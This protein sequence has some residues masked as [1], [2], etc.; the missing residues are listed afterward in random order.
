MLLTNAFVFVFSFASLAA[1]LPG[2]ASSGYDTVPTSKAKETS[3]PPKDTPTYAPP[4]PVSKETVCSTGTSQASLRRCM[5]LKIDNSSVLSTKTATGV[6]DTTYLTT[7]TVY[8][9][10]TTVDEKPKTVITA[11]PY[12]STGYS[13]TVMLQA[14]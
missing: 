13:A 3:K 2:G 4:P 6:K 5:K 8:V 1:A 12:T 9:P 10:V 11:I 14:L 7:K